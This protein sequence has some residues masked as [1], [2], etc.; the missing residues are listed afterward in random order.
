MQG[1]FE[2]L[3]CE[4]NLDQT[5]SADGSSFDESPR[6]VNFRG[7]LLFE[8]ESLIHFLIHLGDASFSFRGDDRRWWESLR[9]DISRRW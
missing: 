8:K 7:H 5:Y 9:R 3:H 2:S 4:V 6:D 1:H